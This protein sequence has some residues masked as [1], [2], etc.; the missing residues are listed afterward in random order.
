[1]EHRSPSLIERLSEDIDISIDRAALGFAGERDI[2]NP[3][4]TN[5]MRKALDEQLRTAITAEVNS[6]ILT[7]LNNPVAST[8]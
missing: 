2:A 5:T 4:L 1:V 7:K 3:S 8:P 6:R